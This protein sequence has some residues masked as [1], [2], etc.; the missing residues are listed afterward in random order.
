MEYGMCSNLFARRTHANQIISY[1]QRASAQMTA[2]GRTADLLSATIPLQGSV[3][4]FS[5]KKST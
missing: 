2:E 3:D 1:S 5:H 4:P